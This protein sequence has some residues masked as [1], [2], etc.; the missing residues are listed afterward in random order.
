VDFPAI[1]TTFSS[2]AGFSALR[3]DCCL[4]CTERSGS[5]GSYF[6]SADLDGTF[7]SPDLSRAFAPPQLGGSFASPDLAGSF[8]GLPKRCRSSRLRKPACGQFLF[9]RQSPSAPVRVFTQK[10]YFIWGCFLHFYY[11]PTPLVVQGCQYRLHKYQGQYERPKRIRGFAVLRVHGS[12]HW[13]RRFFAAQQAYINLLDRMRF[14][15]LL[16]KLTRRAS[17]YY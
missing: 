3:R 2:G 13:L 9:I 7:G 16:M 1:D 14:N 6:A 11:A 8:S 15:T 17:G 10:M 5:V 4:L 12:I